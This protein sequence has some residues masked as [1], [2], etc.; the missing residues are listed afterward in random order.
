MIK[1]TVYDVETGLIK[2]IGECPRDQLRHQ[3]QPGED[4]I[5]GHLDAQ[6]QKLNPRTKRIEPH[7][8]EKIDLDPGAKD[9]RIQ[10]MRA[11][12]SVGDQLDVLWKLVSEMDSTNLQVSSMCANIKA[13][14]AKYPKE[15]TNG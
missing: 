2:R 3:A 11:Y 10:R 14:K 8:P 12:P 15:P 6:T 9:Y 5:E 13:V 7:T 1:F 4:M